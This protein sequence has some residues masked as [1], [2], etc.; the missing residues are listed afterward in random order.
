MTRGTSFRLRWVGCTLHGSRDFTPENL[1]IDSQYWA[2]LAPRHPRVASLFEWTD[3]RELRA[4]LWVVDRAGWM[5]TMRE[6]RLS[7]PFSPNAE[8][9]S[10]RVEAT[11]V[12]SRTS[13]IWAAGHYRTVVQYFKPQQ[14]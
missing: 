11:V 5:C 14:I 6:H 4:R 10:P 13:S 1:P 3:S 9:L 8:A 2:G 7:T 12:P